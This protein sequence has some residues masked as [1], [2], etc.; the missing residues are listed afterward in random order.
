MFF[1]RGAWSEYVFFVGS[2]VLVYFF[3]GAWFLYVFSMGNMVV[4]YKYG[5]QSMVP[6]FRI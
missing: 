5:E 3:G 2:M 6:E 1:L 4:V